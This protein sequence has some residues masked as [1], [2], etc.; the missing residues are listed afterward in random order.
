MKVIFRITTLTCLSIA[1]ITPCAVSEAGLFDTNKNKTPNASGEKAIEART[2][3]TPLLPDNNKRPGSFAD[4]AE[5]LLPTVV[6]ISSTVKIPEAEEMENVVPHFPE[7][8]PFEDFFERFMDQ[9]LPGNPMMPSSSLGSGFVIDA[10]KGYIITNNHVIKDAEE[11]RVTLHNDA[12]VEAEIIGR[13]EKTDLA[14]LKIDPT[15]KNL[16]AAPFGDSDIIRV[17]D[18]ILAIGNP[19][20]LGGTVTAGIISARARD[21]NSGPYD[22]YLQT[23]ASINRGNSGGPMF[24]LQGEVIGINTAI[25]SPTG[26]SVGIGFAIP[27]ALA[28]PI[29][30]QL[31]EYG[32]TRRG[33]LGVRIQSVTDEIAESLGLDKARGALVASITPGGPAESAGI[34]A[35]DIILEFNGTKIDE[36]KR[37]PRVVAETKIETD[38][39]VTVLRK[40]EERKLTV[41][42]G[43]LEKAEENGLLDS[44]TQLTR[45][46]TE[47]EELGIALSELTGDLRNEYSVD[48]TIENGILITDVNPASDAATRGL[49]EGD[50]IVEINQTAV[51]TVADVKK[52]VADAKAQKRTTVLL[53][54]NRS[55]D[56]RFVAIKIGENE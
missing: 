27:M 40:G 52:A 25:F 17:G 28:K 42:I 39:P 18:W 22:D 54:V 46:G 9:Q 55:S 53:L 33:W 38:V 37:L 19:F 3:E 4:M 24:N 13:D 32:H 14:V 29:I 16:T 12:T 41:K 2:I 31:I 45:K 56:V 11:V 15:G 49:I 47:L 43:E 10:E 30:N 34:E 21:I 1:L 6:N 51:N 36:M 23:D 7:G 50:V 44:Q 8:S 20:G 48:E 5:I 35:G 26:G